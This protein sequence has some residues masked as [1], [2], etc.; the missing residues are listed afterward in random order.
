MND[1]A[2][3]PAPAR[4]RTGAGWLLVALV[5]L[6]AAGWYG[7]QAWQAQQ[8]RA[9]AWAAE[10]TQQW[11]ALDARID[12][13]RVDQR[14]QAQRLQQAD[15]TNRVLREELLGIG[16]RA[17]LLEDSVRKLADPDRD[18]AQALRLDEVDLLLGQGEQRLRIAGDLDGARDAYALAAGV[19]EGIH[20]GAGGNAALLNL[21]QALVQERATLDALAQDPKVAALAQL[22]RFAASLSLPATAPSPA[23]AARPWWQRALSRI[24]QVQPSNAAVAV[25]GGERAAA[26]A[27][28]QLEL[29]L[30][31]AAIER[32]DTAAYRAALGRADGWIARLW[33]DS[34]QRRAR[35]AALQALRAQPLVLQLPA[36]GSTRR[37]LQALGHGS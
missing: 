34:P 6:A 33:P 19:L 32:R 13:L 26:F 35:R 27:A 22:D 37:Q 24:V 31:R 29:T 7:W 1:A 28:L 12:A 16:Q 4:R 8:R 17:A 14:A 30:A 21:R 20:P 23:T 9:R 5:V 25:A 15:A 11:Q 3:L 10:T 2:P 18:G 36:L